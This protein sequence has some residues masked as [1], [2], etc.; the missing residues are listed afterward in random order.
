MY[1]FETAG[2][3]K[4]PAWKQDYICRMYY[5][6]QSLRV[7]WKLWFFAV[8][9]NTLVVLYPVFSL[10][11]R[12]STRFPIA[13]RL[14]RVWS[15]VLMSTIL[16]WIKIEKKVPLPKKPYIICPNHSSYLDIVSMY[17]VFGDYFIFMGKMEINSWPLFHIFFTK[18]MNI[19]VNRKSIIGA[20]SALERAK[21]EVDK[22]NNIVI[23]PEGT[24]PL[25]APYMKPFKNG[26]FKLA[27]EKNI[28]IIPVTFVT[29]WRRLQAGPAL[30]R[31]G[32]PGVSHVI[33]HA[34]VYPAD[35]GAGGMERMKSDIFATIQ[36]P[37]T[38]YYGSE[39]PS[40]RQAFEPGAVNV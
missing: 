33:V 30:R 36:K 34:P 10:L 28:P 16:V 9:A 13:F 37:L 8:F 18:G 4:G 11:L 17:R 5:L 40:D 21:E 6:K 26:A 23:F 7:L 39:R 22:G 19:S 2:R 20:H 25:N 38:K 35:Y 32:G 31:G 12:K 1:Q 15:T 27:M 14:M 24:I 29:N 3:F